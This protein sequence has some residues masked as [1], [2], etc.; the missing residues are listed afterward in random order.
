M[1]PDLRTRLL[2]AITDPNIAFLLL[3]LGVYGLI[4]EFS[5]PGIF[6]PGVVGAISL[7]LGLFALSIIPVDLAGLGLTVLGLALMVAEAFVPSFGALG[8]G[9]AVA[10]VL[11]AMMTF[12]TPGY[13]LAWPVAIGARGLQ[14]RPLHGGPG[15]AGARAA[16]TGEHR[17][18]RAGRRPC[19]GDRRGPA[20]V[21]RS[22]SMGERWRAAGRGRSR[23]DSRFASS[24]ATG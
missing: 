7:L 11:G 13:R 1:P 22:R 17:R 18:R 12:D 15:H 5:H 24:D 2:A 19:H 21:A 16:P 14:R 9:G 8:I 6:A 23:R 20:R 3:L 4:F 10:F